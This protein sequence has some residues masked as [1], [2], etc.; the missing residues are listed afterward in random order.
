M[1]LNLKTRGYGLAALL[2][3]L[4]RYP[5]SWLLSGRRGKSLS[6]T[7][8]ADETGI[9]FKS[10]TG[11]VLFVQTDGLAQDTTLVFI[12]GINSSRQQWQHQQQYFRRYYRLILIDL[13]GHGRSPEPVDL[14]IKSL[15]IDLSHILTTM[16][17]R[18][19][20]L[21]GH[22]LGGMIIQEYWKL[23]LSPTPKAIILQS[24]SYTNPLKAM[25][26]SP[27]PHLLQWPVIIPALRY[28]SSKTSAFTALG[29]ASYS[30]GISALFYRFLLFSG[31]QSAATL[32]KMADFAKRVKAKTSAEAL[33][34]AF[35]FDAG[36]ALKTIHVPCL[37]IA[38]RED[39]LIA[40]E[41]ARRL[42][43]Q[44]K[45]SELVIVDGGHQS[46]A[47]FPEQTNRAVRSFLLK[48]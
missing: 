8:V 42:H 22:S 28:I 38:A 27:I 3:L 21:H 31:G 34:H 41:V 29:Y 33:L 17:I 39:R 46:L 1:K 13:P 23:K 47:E 19:A 10:P 35:A 30:S 37:I 25:P 45:D 7:D 4:G 24:C 20:I 36:S 6:D 48:Q 15:A 40:T 26:I 16:G 14:S 5:V 44:I 43:K 32:R 18:Q 2:F 11:N 9:F 12:H